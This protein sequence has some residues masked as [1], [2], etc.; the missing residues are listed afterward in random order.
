MREHAFQGHVSMETI[1]GEQPGLG[2]A[3]ESL[4]RPA[5]WIFVSVFDAPC[6]STDRLDAAERGYRPALG[7]PASISLHDGPRSLDQAEIADT[8]DE[9]D[10]TPIRDAGIRRDACQQS[11]EDVRQDDLATRSNSRDEPKRIASRAN[12]NAEEVAFSIGQRSHRP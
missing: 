5:V 9:H 11:A 6:S 4:V 3:D 2:V 7:I 12:R 8:N 1:F 10:A